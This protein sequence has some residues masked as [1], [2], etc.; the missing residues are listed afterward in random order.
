MSAVR[1]IL[2]DD[3]QV[4]RLGLRTLLESE[5]DL[6]VVGEAADGLEAIRL[7][8]K[9][10]PQ[11]AILDLQ[12]PGLNG[13]ETAR[14]LRARFPSMCIVMLSMFDSEAYVVEALSAGASAY[15]LKQ[16]TTGDLVTAV[17]EVLM[18]KRYLSPSL[19][20]RA[21]EAYIHYVQSARTGEL[22]VIES[23]TPREREVLHL[24][25]RGAT[26]AEI[27]GRL[28]LSPRT[29]DTHRAQMMRKLGLHSQVDL[30]RFAMERGILPENR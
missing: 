12:M 27:A 5:P 10:S 1:L 2:A 29:V 16:A 9:L 14:Q 28:S 30:V 22:D 18:G 13:I 23:L 3:H 24:V 26:T 4:V 6:Q 11:V 21:I 8:E 17:R 25:A 20:E 19:S 7:A 15:V